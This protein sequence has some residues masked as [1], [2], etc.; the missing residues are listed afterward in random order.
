M[1]NARE[2]YEYIHLQLC[3][4][5]FGTVV[6]ERNLEELVLPDEDDMVILSCIEFTCSICWL[7]RIA[8]RVEAIQKLSAKVTADF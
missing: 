8:R 1:D 4:A 2:M 6:C 7:G 3:F 5:E